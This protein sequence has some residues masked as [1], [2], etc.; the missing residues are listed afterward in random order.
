MV[1]KLKNQ[2][3]IG[4]LCDQIGI[5]YQL[6]RLY[7]RGEVGIR[8]AQS[9]QIKSKILKVFDESR[10]TYGLDRML[11]ALRSEG[12]A[13]GKTRLSRLMKELD[14]Q[15]RRKKRFIPRTTDSNHDN[16][17]A[18]NILP[19]KDEIKAVNRVWQGDITYIR[20]SEGWLYLSIVLD[21]YSR[22]IAGWSFSDSLASNLV[23]DALKMALNRSENRSTSLL[24]HSDRGV[25]YTS[26][27]YRNLLSAN[28]ITASMSR[29]GNCY[30]NAKSESFF[31]TLKNELVHRCE[32]KTRQE[33]K[34]SI[35]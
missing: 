7:S 34:I 32:Y 6:Y 14:L 24:F 1:E 19:L 10:Q 25:Q 30:D 27:N 12:I 23:E 21:S 5:N 2:F 17:V 3:P 8:E 33:A 28:T 18:P 13:V 9:K 35:L 20:T 4:Q 26:K 11:P 16:P 31:S 29:K 22:K 15:P